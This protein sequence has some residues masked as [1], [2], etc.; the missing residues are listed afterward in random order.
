MEGMAMLALESAARRYVLY[1][2]MGTMEYCG[3]GTGTRGKGH[4]GGRYYRR[5]AL[6]DAADHV[7][8][9]NVSSDVGE[10]RSKL[11]AV[12]D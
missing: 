2:C 9:E 4:F 5:V 6:Q 1:F 11:F 7:V 12:D 3:Q 8:G 10:R